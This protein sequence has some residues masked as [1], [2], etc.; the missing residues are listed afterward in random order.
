MPLETKSTALVAFETHDSELEALLAQAKATLAEKEK[1]LK[2]QEAAKS[3]SRK[4][5]LQGL[6][7]P[8]RSDAGERSSD[9]FPLK[10]DI[11]TGTINLDTNK[12]HAKSSPK[13][14]NDNTNGS[15]FGQSSLLP[16]I[17]K[18]IGQ[19]DPTVKRKSLS[20]LAKEKEQTAGKRW[21]GMK[22]PV[23]TQELKN[24]LRV[25]QLRG[26]ID[27]KRF[28]KKDTT[29]KQLPKYFEVG[30]V[31]EGPTEFYS[32]RMT[33]KE[34]RTNIVDEL[35]ADKQARDYFKRKVSEIHTRN[36]SGNK[37][38]YSEN[39]HGKGKKWAKSSKVSK[40]KRK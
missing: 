7:I 30:T 25:L 38:W 27:P 10:M 31:I 11:A 36:S 13:R 20:A 4:Q 15:S 14:D 29:S 28:Y 18:K 39:S 19:Y 37:R 5:K 26:V 2:E 34:R 23:M 16:E 1:K 40:S 17:E 22:A 9:L 3:G 6:T 12:I 35:M 21:F 33:K 8:W 32:S 24:D